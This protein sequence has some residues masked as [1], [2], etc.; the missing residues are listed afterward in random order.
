F[1]CARRTSEW[2]LYCHERSFS[3][4]WGVSMPP[5]DWSWISGLI[6]GLGLLLLL[7]WFLY[8]FAGPV[9]SFDVVRTARRSRSA[10]LRGLYARLLLL[11]L[12][13]VYTRWFNL[14]PSEALAGIMEERFIPSNE[15]ARFAAAFF[16]T[17]LAVQFL[18]MLFLTPALTAGAI[19]EEREK[20]T[21]SE[22]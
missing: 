20:G 22:L 1:S 19:A 13:V 17:F 3:G 15:R 14:H 6:I 16:H 2:N 10:L 8:R 7:A 12:F 18:T 5:L 11:V 4:S 21:L 9:F